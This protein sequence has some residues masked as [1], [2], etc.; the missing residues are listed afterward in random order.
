M[1]MY[2]FI[3]EGDIVVAKNVQGRATMVCKRVVARQGDLVL[4]KD[5]FSQ[6][7]PGFVW[8]EGDNSLES[9]DSR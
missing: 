1:M 3:L 4:V 8:L 2:L 9:Y 7:P 5:G 6:V